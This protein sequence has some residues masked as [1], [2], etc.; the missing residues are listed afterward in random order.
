MIMVTERNRQTNWRDNEDLLSPWLIDIPGEEKGRTDFW[1]EQCLDGRVI[2]EGFGV[3]MT[4]VLD[5]LDLRCL[6]DI[7][8]EM[9]SRHQDVQVWSLEEWSG[10]KYSRWPNPQKW[11]RRP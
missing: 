6:W 1:L 5:R 2:R 9:L 3:I 7:Q 11:K 10:S 4:L 8:V